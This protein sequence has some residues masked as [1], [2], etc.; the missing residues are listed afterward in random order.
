M[1]QFDESTAIAGP[2]SYILSLFGKDDLNE[3]LLLL[4]RL[5][6][7]LVRLP[8]PLLLL[9]PLL[10]EDITEEAREFERAIPLFLCKRFVRGDGETK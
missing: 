9:L 2:L 1:P 8:V 5:L 7:R 4:L 6:A 3:M 10:L